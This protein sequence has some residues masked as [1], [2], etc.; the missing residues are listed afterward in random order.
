MLYYNAQAKVEIESNLSDSFNLGIGVLQGDTLAPFLVIVVIDWV[1]RN[2]IPLDQLHFLG[3]QLTKP[4]G[5]KSR[6]TS[7]AK[8]STDLDYCDDIC[9]ISATLEGAQNS[10]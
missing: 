8:Y 4:T 2:T 9:L 10:C 5:T 1:L 3:F 7:A 6:P